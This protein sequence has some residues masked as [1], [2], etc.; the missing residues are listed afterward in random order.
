MTHGDLIPGNVLVAGGRLLSRKLI[1]IP[2]QHVQATLANP[3]LEGFDARLALTR[4]DVFRSVVL[5]SAPF[6]GPPAP[7][8]CPS[9]GAGS[10]AHKVPKN[11]PSSR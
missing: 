11:D 10:I 5:M 1:E 2:N 9:R 4:P 7:I 6:G 3:E 8:L